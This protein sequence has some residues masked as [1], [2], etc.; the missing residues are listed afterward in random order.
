M[1]DFVMLSDG[2]RRKRRKHTEDFGS[3]LEISAG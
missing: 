1:K 3:V 2:Y